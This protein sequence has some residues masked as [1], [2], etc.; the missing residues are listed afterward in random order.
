MNKIEPSHFFNRVEE[1]L[2]SANGIKPLQ[3]LEEFVK[4]DGASAEIVDSVVNGALLDFV[5]DCVPAPNDFVH[6]Y[7]PDGKAIYVKKV[8][9]TFD[10]WADSLTN[11]IKGIKRERIVAILENMYDRG[12]IQKSTSNSCIYRGTAPMRRKPLV[13]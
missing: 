5:F 3:A 13:L 12:I 7:G 2:H 9:M 6:V 8:E 1:Y 10:Q 4:M 11:T